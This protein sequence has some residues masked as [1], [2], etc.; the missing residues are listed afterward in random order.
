ML[1]AGWKRNAS[2]HC[3]ERLLSNLC[4][5][6]KGDTRTFF[7]HFEAALS[8][9]FMTKTDMQPTPHNLTF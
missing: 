5:A 7:G 9:P 2:S 1:I 4:K 8:C 6:L 3:P